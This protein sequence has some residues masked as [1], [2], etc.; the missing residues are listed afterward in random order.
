MVD[1]HAADDDGAGLQRLHQKGDDQAHKL[2]RSAVVSSADIDVGESR[3]GTQT[4]EGR[5]QGLEHVTQK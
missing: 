4:Y 3:V 2:S 5:R 1:R